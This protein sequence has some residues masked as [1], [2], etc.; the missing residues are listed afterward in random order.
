[1]LVLSEVIRAS[2]LSLGDGGE[3][4]GNIG[5]VVGVGESI[6]LL[7]FLLP[8]V[9]TAGSGSGIKTIPPAAAPI[10]VPAVDSLPAN[11]RMPHDQVPFALS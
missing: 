5:A 3:E 6:S 4:L 7:S 8:G 1:M 9:L 11:S 10:A 2:W